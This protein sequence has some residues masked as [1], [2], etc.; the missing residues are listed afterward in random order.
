MLLYTFV[1]YYMKDSQ[2]LILY[3]WCSKIIVYYTLHC[4]TWGGGKWVHLEVI[5]DIRSTQEHMIQLG[6][7]KVPPGKETL[8]PIWWEVGG[9]Q[10]WS[11]RGDEE[12]N[13]FPVSGV[14]P[15]SSSPDP[16][17]FSDWAIAISYTRDEKWHRTHR[18]TMCTPTWCTPFH[19]GCLHSLGTTFCGNR[20]NLPHGAGSILL[21][22]VE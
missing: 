16:I 15:G 17:K 6:I 5:S 22:Q 20:R 14:E 8:V 21:K 12:K 7:C 19:S 9:P 4:C 13:S 18:E 1:E 3:N 10:I 11:G 2:H